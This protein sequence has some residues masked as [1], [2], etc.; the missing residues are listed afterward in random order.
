MNYDRIPKIPCGH[1]GG[2]GGTLLAKQDPWSYIDCSR[3]SAVSCKF[4]A[5]SNSHPALLHSLLCALYCCVSPTHASRSQQLLT[6]NAQHVT[7][8]SKMQALYARSAAATIRRNGIP[9]ISAATGARAAAFRLQSQAGTCIE[10]QQRG[11]AVER[12]VYGMKVAKGVEVSD[13]VRR[14]LSIENGDM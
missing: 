10:R 4:A 13:P 7:R 9:Y 3:H 14:V 1:E 5:L 2:R 12:M 6:R 11:L 8:G